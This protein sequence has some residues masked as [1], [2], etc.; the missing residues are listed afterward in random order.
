[1]INGV[2]NAQ[3]QLPIAICSSGTWN[4]LADALR[5]PSPVRVPMLLAEGQTTSIP[6]FLVEW[7]QSGV[8]SR[9]YAFMGV[10]FGLGARVVASTEECKK[11]IPA[12]PSMFWQYLIGPAFLLTAWSHTVASTK[13]GRIKLEPCLPEHRADTFIE[14]D[15]CVMLWAHARDPYDGSFDRLHVSYS[16]T[17]DTPWFPRLAL[18]FA[19]RQLYQGMAKICPNNRPVDAFT[20]TAAEDFDFLI[21]GE[22]CRA[23]FVSVKVCEDKRVD[24]FVPASSGLHQ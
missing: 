17:E 4:I 8:L 6:L 14:A 12:L 10:D 19:L 20:V 23:D 15:E 5:L 16:T 18:F 3:H 1:M 2:V 9:R 24:I 21:D 11:M 7:R 22:L 13:G